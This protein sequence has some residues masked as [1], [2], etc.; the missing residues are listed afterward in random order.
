MKKKMGRTAEK[1]V[2]RENLFLDFLNCSCHKKSIIVMQ[3]LYFHNVFIFNFKKI[4]N[5]AVDFI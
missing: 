4:I 3:I 2:V 5:R 1:E